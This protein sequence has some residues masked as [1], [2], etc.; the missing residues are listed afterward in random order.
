[1][2]SDLDESKT[3][4]ENICSA[5]LASEQEIDKTED[6]AEKQ[7]VKAENE[8][9]DDDVQLSAFTMSALQ[10]FVSEQLE[11]EQRRQQAEQMAQ[12]AAQDPDQLADF[13]EDWVSW[14]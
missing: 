1:M 13:E 14:Q 5:K 4:S 10:E 3:R 12:D 11:R 2:M 6:T 9:E 8:E 7:T